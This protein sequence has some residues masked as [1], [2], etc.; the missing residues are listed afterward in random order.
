MSVERFDHQQCLFNM[1]MTAVEIFSFPLLL[2]VHTK[3]NILVQISLYIVCTYISLFYLRE[4]C[5]VKFVE[6]REEIIKWVSKLGSKL[7]ALP[8]FCSSLLF[9][10]IQASIKAKL[11]K[12]DDPE[13]YLKDFSDLYTR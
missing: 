5:V 7:P 4:C 13:Q 8:C 1:N 3:Q 6:V 9:V 2:K 10:L 12:Q 11:D